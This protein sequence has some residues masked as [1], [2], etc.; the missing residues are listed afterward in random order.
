MSSNPEMQIYMYFK[1]AYKERKKYVNY[2]EKEEI[3]CRHKK[4]QYWSSMQK[5]GN[6]YRQQE[7]ELASMQKSRKYSLVCKKEEI[8]VQYKEKEKT[9]VQ[10]A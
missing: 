10:Y 4:I 6:E 5:E 3:Y 7:N 9:S 2:T 8:Q 1:N